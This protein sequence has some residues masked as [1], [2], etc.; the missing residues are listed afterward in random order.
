M[1]VKYCIKNFKSFNRNV[2]LRNELEGE[3]ARKEI[4]MFKIKLD[5]FRKQN[6]VT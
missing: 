1:K 2:D 5:N 6:R 3:A 4:G